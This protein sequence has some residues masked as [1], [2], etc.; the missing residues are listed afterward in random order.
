MRDVRIAV[1]L[2][3]SALAS[4]EHL[5]RSLAGTHSFPAR[6]TAA[7]V[8]AELSDRVDDGIRRR[9]SWER[10]WLRSAFPLEALE[11]SEQPDPAAPWRSIV[12]ERVE[13][14]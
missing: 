1:S 13:E 10:S 6:M 11:A 2:S 5:A 12:P 9:G 14:P 3:P 7:D 8:L 4:L